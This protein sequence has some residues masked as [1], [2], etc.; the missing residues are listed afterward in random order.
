MIF[1]NAFLHSIKLPRK[2]AIFQLN[3]IGMDITII[4]M[5]I[6]LL[7]ISIPSLIDR[8]TNSSSHSADLSF[9]FLIIYFF[10]F[11]Y[12]PMAII[13]FILL[14]AIAYIGTN[15]A[16]IM[17]RKLK[18]SIIWKMTAFTTTVPFFLYALIALTT[19]ISDHYLWFFCV[20][21]LVLLIMIISVYPKRRT[22]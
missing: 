16:K 4:Y 3:R 20:Y 18:F 15:L 22:K 17:G 7:L 9:I 2:K 5:F 6:L 11:Y 14:S 8:I 21:S 12:L 10:I 1:L 19:P 13:V